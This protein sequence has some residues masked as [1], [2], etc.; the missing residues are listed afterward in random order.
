MVAELLLAGMLI[1]V[2]AEKA[3]GVASAIED[4]D[5]LSA[6]IAKPFDVVAELPNLV[7]V[8]QTPVP[9]RFVTTTCEITS[10]I[11][12]T[13]TTRTQLIKFMIAEGQV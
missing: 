12:K 4:A 8:A 7:S 3:S 9:I 11:D 5:E 1:F 6:S 13:H 10:G 2:V